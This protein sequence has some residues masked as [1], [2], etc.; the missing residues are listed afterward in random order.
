MMK[1]KL[2]DLF[3]YTHY[4]NREIIEVIAGNIA[5]VDERIIRLINHTLNAQQIWNARIIGEKTFDVWQTN[6]FENLEGINSSNHQ[7]SIG[8]INDSDLDQRIE[9]HNSKGTTFENSIFEMLFHAV[10]HSTY[11]RGQINMLLKNSSIDPVPA[12][13]IFYKR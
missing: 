1:E 7:K 11:H 2:I 10:N 6:P 4:F 12:D 13:Y 8:I 3:D 9:Y 5:K